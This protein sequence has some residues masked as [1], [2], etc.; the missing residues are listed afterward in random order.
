MALR[1]DADQ[2]QATTVPAEPGPQRR[3]TPDPSRNASRPASS[4]AWP[5]RPLRRTTSRP[6][7][8][9]RSRSDGGSPRMTAPAPYRTFIF[10]AANR[11]NI[12][13]DYCYVFNAKDDA[14]RRMPHA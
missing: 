8:Q 1:M 14:W 10:K 4:T 13:C 2:P 3:G 9:R 5:T 6:C 7:T 12:D 11:C